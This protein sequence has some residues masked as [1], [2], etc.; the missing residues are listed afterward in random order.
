MKRAST[1]LTAGAGKGKGASGSSGWAVVEGRVVVG[2]AVEG[3]VVVVSVVGV[4][5]SRVSS[6][7]LARVLGS[8]LPGSSEK[9]EAL[10]SGE[11]ADPS[12]TL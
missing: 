7:I 4:G 10:L 1:V 12:E 5:S 9:G 3:R 2:W 6:A 11:A 8:L